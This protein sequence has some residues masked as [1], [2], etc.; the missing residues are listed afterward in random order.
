MEER[1][2][3][4]ISAAHI[5]SRRAAEKMILEGRVTVNGT[6]A[7]IGQSADPARD[8]VRVDGV[9]LRF[10]GEHTYLI[11][12]K[13]RGYVTTLSDERGRRTVAELV[14]GAGVRVYPVGRLDYDSDGLLLMTDDGALA[15]AMTHPS[16]EINKTYRVAVRGNLSRALPLLR[17]P[18]ELDGVPLRRAR[19]EAAGE[20]CLDI[21]IHEGRKRQVRR[22]C[23]LAGLT[24]SR[25]TRIA[26]G[27]LVLGDLP[28]RSWRKLSKTEEDAI[29]IAVF[30][31]TQR[32]F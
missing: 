23:A 27:P 21:T 26:E 6:R 10:A 16:H 31:G 11:L 8:E 1:L 30:G 22:M 17:G 32:N 15:H 13:P 24:V 25:L 14:R 19:V 2:Q 29:K 3:K 7:Q 18:M 5:A 28:P 12:N 4:L 20:G 9:P